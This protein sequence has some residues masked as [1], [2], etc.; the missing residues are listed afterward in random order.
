MMVHY[1]IIQ[2]VL[3]GV[4]GFHEAEFGGGHVIKVIQSFTKAF[5]HSLTFPERTLKTLAEKGV[6]NCAG[7]AILVHN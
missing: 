7:L 6:K 1:G 3:I 4:A 5:E 2:T